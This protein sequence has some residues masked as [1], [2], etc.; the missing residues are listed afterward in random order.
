MLE[1]EVRI[2]RKVSNLTAAFVLFD[3]IISLLNPF[4]ILFVNIRVLK[5]LCRL[6]KRYGYI[7]FS[8]LFNSFRSVDV[9]YIPEHT[10]T[11]IDLFFIG[12]FIIFKCHA[13]NLN[14]FI[15]SYFTFDLT[16]NL[17]KYSNYIVI[18]TRNSNNEDELM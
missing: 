18:W 2:Y 8:Y 15:R 17:L 9:W 12:Y 1:T 16:H 7:L 6:T 5:L 10:R 13:W 11:S 4:T 14:C 3:N